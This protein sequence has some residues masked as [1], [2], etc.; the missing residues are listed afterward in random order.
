MINFFRIASGVAL[1]AALAWLVMEPKFDS[2]VAAA[3]AFA[4]FIGSML[5]KKERLPKTREQSQN[6]NNNSTAIQAGGDINVEN[7]GGI[8]AGR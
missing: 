7:S 2:V 5:V 1:L 3:T 4:A 6:V 8:R